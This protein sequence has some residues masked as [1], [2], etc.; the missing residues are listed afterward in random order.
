[1]WHV[2]L[3]NFSPRDLNPRRIGL[4]WSASRVCYLTSF[5]FVGNKLIIS[6]TTRIRSTL[7]VIGENIFKCLLSISLSSTALSTLDIFSHFYFMIF[8]VDVYSSFMIKIKWII[9]THMPVLI[10]YMLFCIKLSVDQQNSVYIF[11][12]VS[13]S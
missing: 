2:L 1:M 13:F 10:I 12:H 5:K 7:H 4:M 3:F 6:C 9:I 11:G 8:I